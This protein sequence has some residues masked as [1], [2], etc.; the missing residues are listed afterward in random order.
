M[1][2]YSHASPPRLRYGPSRLDVCVAVRALSVQ[3]E[4]CFPAVSCL[5]LFLFDD[6]RHTQEAGRRGT[7]KIRR[8]QQLQLQL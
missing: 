3:H 7:N 6:M 1:A 5:W 4:S 8:R 2:G